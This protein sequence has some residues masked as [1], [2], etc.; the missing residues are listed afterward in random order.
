MFGVQQ[1]QANQ[2]K[3][4]TMASLNKIAI[5]CTNGSPILESDETLQQVLPNIDIFLQ[6]YID[7]AQEDDA[8]LVE[9]E[10]NE[11]EDQGSDDSIGNEEQEKEEARYNGGTLFVTSKNLYCIFNDETGFKWHFSEI[12]THAVATEEKEPC[13]FCQVERR[14]KNEEYGGY[15]EVFFEARLIP[16]PS[17]AS[18]DDV[19]LLINKT[20]ELFCTI[21]SSVPDLYED[22]SNDSSGLNMDE[23]FFNA[24]EARKALKVHPLERKSSKDDSSDEDVDVHELQNKKQKKK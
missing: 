8:V 15:E 19:K 22:N 5:P 12:V 18:A 7:A 17:N 4:L 6:R 24:D 1:K 14:I 21:A 20:Y 9:E 3:T 11:D 2:N 10:N 13:L 23:M 16:K